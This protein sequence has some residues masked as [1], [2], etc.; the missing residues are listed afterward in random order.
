MKVRSGFVSNSSSVSFQIYGI[1][2][3][4]REEFEELVEQDIFEFSEQ[5]DLETV[6]GD[7]MSFRQRY[8]IGLIAFGDFENAFYSNMRGLETKDEFME[9]AKERLPQD[10]A[11]K[12]N[13]YSESFYDG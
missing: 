1:E 10:L 7:P 5:R 8:Y 11:D 2:V 3:E 4:N 13:W 6:R 12:V 9:R